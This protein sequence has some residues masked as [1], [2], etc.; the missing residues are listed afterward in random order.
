M[1]ST[2]PPK[3]LSFL[4]GSTAT[5]PTTIVGEHC[6]AIPVCAMQRLRCDLRLALRT[7]RRDWPN[8]VLSQGGSCMV[9]YQYI[10]PLFCGICQGFCNWSLP[11]LVSIRK[12]HG[13]VLIALIC[14]LRRSARE[15]NPNTGTYIIMSNIHIVL[16][17]FLLFCAIRKP[18]NK[19]RHI[20]QRTRALS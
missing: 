11:V 4:R 17:S 6:S 9:L 3:K 13:A 15:T 16:L 20:S 8:K 2:N 10:S 19:S 12:I 14:K 18:Q 1:F 7:Q 5:K